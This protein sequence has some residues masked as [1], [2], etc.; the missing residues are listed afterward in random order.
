MILGLLSQQGSQ[1]STNIIESTIPMVIEGKN[2]AESFNGNIFL[3][4]IIII[5]DPTFHFSQ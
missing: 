1:N 5:G 2:V 4:N 3:D